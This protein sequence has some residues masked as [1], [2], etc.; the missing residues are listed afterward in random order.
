MRFTLVYMTHNVYMYIFF[1]KTLIYKLFSIQWY[2][3]GNVTPSSLITI[4]ADINTITEYSSVFR[5]A[6]IIYDISSI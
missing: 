6:E 3:V 1:V 4:L 5:C 2:P